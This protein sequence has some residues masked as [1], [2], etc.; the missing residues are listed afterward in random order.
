MERARK[1]GKDGATSSGLEGST[2]MRAVQC[3]GV[4]RRTP[5][6][7]RTPGPVRS[8][9]SLGATPLGPLPTFPKA[10]GK[11]QSRSEPTTPR[12][13][14][15]SSLEGSDTSSNLADRL[16][17]LDEEGS[18]TADNVRVLVRVRPLNE[19]EQQDAGS[20]VCVTTN[21]QAVVFS[22]PSRASEPFVQGFDGVFGPEAGQEEVHRVAGISAVEHCLAGYNSSVFAY[23]Q[24]GGCAWAGSGLAAA[25]LVAKCEGACCA[26]GGGSSP[27][28]QGEH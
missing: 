10:R 22:D 1:A 6:V 9:S 26:T 4:V 12:G 18:R 25:A 27:G 17:L 13:S 19:R 14:R 5:A 24:V 8:V 11:A 20:K 7:G 28:K 21:G 15:P 2:P 23:G 16:G 3:S